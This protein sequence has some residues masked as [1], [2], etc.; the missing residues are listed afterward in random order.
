[1]WGCIGCPWDQV[2]VLVN[3]DVIAPEGCGGAGLVCVLP[4][5][6]EKEKGDESHVCDCKGPRHC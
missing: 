2:V 5:V 4:G 6:E 3:L 1:V